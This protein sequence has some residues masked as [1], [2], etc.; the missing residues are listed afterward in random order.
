MVPFQLFPCVMVPFQFSLCAMSFH[1]NGP[2]PIQVVIAHAPLWH[3][4][5]DYWFLSICYESMKD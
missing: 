3:P 2:I 5:A 1:V 4:H